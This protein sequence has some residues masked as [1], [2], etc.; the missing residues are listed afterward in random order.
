LILSLQ[1]IV[2]EALKQ[3]FADALIAFIKTSGVSAVL[4]LSGIDLSDRTDS[5]ML[6]VIPSCTM[7][8]SP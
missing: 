8:S 3:E 1:L 7:S 2:L 4:F 6:Y 5:Q